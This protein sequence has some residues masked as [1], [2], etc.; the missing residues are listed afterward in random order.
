M[1]YRRVR[2][3]GGCY[4]FTVVLAERGADLLVRHIDTL[5]AAFKR[6]K[7]TH[8]MDINA[9][10]VLPDHL[11]CL[12]TL[13]ENDADYSTRWSLIKASFSRQIPKTELIRQSRLKK[14]ERGVWQRR[15]WEHAIRSEEDF[16]NHVHYIHQNPVK[17]KFVSKAEDWRFS[18]IHA[19]GFRYLN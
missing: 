17:H 3:G 4:F 19:A 6:V 10:V 18:S 9:I 14:G 1:E 2:V 11:H 15:F 5:L 7:S 12:W 16:V 13:P 8:P